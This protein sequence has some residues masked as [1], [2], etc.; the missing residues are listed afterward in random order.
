M[1]RKEHGLWRGL[2]F[3]LCLA[4]VC[5]ASPLDAQ[6]I[7][8]WEGYFP[9]GGEI[10]YFEHPMTVGQDGSVT[11]VT[12][13]DSTFL[14]QFSVTAVADQSGQVIDYTILLNSPNTWV[15][16]L[17]AGSYAVRIGRGLTN[18]YGNYT[19][20]ANL[21]PASPGATETE[22]N[23]LI[24]D[25][26]TNP[27]NLFAGA[28]GYIRAKNVKDL[29][30]YYRFTLTGDTNVHFDLTAATTLLDFDTVL[31][32]RNGGDTGLDSTY[33][34][35]ASKT[36]D[37]R[38]AAG[39]YYLRL[40]THDY[41]RYGGYTIATTAT[42]AVA[43]SSET[44]VNDT[45]GAANPIKSK[46]L[47]GSIGYMRD[48]ATYD[49]SDYFACQVS[50]GGTLSAEILSPAT[51]HNSNNTIS[52]RN[53]SN[54]RLNYA[55]LTGSP[56]TVTVNN[57]DAGTYY[58]LVYRAVGYGAYQINVSGNVILPNPAG[59][60]SAILPLLLSD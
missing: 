48:N 13:V 7:G 11:L 22:N 20:T 2:A 32:L 45:L 16:P 15:V 26:N 58:I 28:I 41:A 6:Q 5:W 43:S 21:A 52:I 31:T 47:F 34:N 37:L 30:D 36:W 51:L 9:N 42:P 33:L 46:T 25:A 57:L 35:L 50:Q 4:L 60:G 3:C 49:D 23:D 18:T 40:F 55:Y 10:Y 14:G 53:A 1:V 24:A 8:D 27:N 19:I 38:L 54:T 44:E 39:T 56:R 29:S 59:K 12:T 17:A